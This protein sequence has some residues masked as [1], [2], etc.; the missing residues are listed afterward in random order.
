MSY[1]AAVHSARMP[2]RRT[3]CSLNVMPAGLGT[4]QARGRAEELRRPLDEEPAEEL[5]EW[6]DDHFTSSAFAQAEL[7]SEQFSQGELR[8]VLDHLDDEA[9]PSAASVA[10]EEHQRLEKQLHDELHGLGDNHPAA[11]V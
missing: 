10:S 5:Q 11:S 6:R 7:H 3:G 8:R 4:W 1:E 9:V 2:A